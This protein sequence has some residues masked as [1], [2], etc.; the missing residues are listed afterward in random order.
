MFPLNLTGMKAQALWIYAILGPSSG[1]YRVFIDEKFQDIDGYLLWQQAGN[2]A[3]SCQLLFSYAGLNDNASHVAE[4][5][6][7]GTS[8]HA[9]NQG[10]PQLTISGVT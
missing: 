2:S 1:T 10:D 7:Q 3:P 5:F 8:P 9:T 4:V 6:V